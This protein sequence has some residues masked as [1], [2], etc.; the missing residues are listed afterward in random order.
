[1]NP[2]DLREAFRQRRPMLEAFGKWVTDRVVRE[3]KEVLGASYSDYFFKVHPHHRVKD[4]EGFVEKSSR[5]GKGYL[6]PL[7]EITDQVG[8]RFVVLLHDQSQIVNKA[9]QAVPEWNWIQAKDIEEVR[10]LDPHHFDYESYHWTVSPKVSMEIG[11]LMITPDTTCEIQVRTLLQHAYAELAH[12][13]VYKPK[14]TARPEVKRIIARGAALIETTDGVFQRV[15]DEIQK[16]SGKLDELLRGAAAWYASSVEAGQYPPSGA[17]LRITD[18]YVEDL[19]QISWTDMQAYL[20]GKN[21]IVSVIVENR[22]RP[23]FDDPVIVLVF[24][25]VSE[26]RHDVASHWP[27]DISLLQPVFTKLGIAPE[28]HLD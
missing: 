19:S 26:L 7:R 15:A 11:G 2:E 28:G 24:W 5:T 13:T 10:S 16:V 8:T 23:L 14:T 27:F 6:D 3:V 4:I 12:S 21:W 17:A 18:A 9:I 25:L 22:N 1:M 20:D